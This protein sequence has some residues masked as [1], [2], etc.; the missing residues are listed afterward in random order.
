MPIGRPIANTQVYLLDPFL[1]P[2]PIGIPGELYIG[3]AN[4]AR[5]YLDRP[6]LTAERFLPHPFSQQPGARLYRTGDLACYL[7]DGSLEFLGRID[8]QV[9]LRGFRIELGEIEAVLSQHPAIQ[10][11]VV[12]LREDVPGDQRLVAYVVPHTE[13]TLPLATSELR[14]FLKEKLPD[15]MLPSAFVVLDCLPMTPNGKHDRRALRAPETDRPDL[16]VAFAVPRTVLEAQVAAIWG[17]V[18]RL[19]RVGVYD[20]F[21]E[22]GGHSLLATQVI[23]RIRNTFHVEMPLRRL[24]EAPTVAGLAEYL[25]T[26]QPPTQ[27]IPS[28]QI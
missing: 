2:V 24:F 22:L 7:P 18:L 9:K 10:E 26:S 15:Y 3:G 20:N 21:F 6:E 23:S 8:Q 17:E 27:D 25:A 13:T 12:L 5:G 11:S 28:V 19:Q 1:Q 4:L 14:H 16:P